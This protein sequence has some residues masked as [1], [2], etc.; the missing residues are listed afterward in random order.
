M[1][2]GGEYDA[3]QQVAGTA[4]EMTI[5]DRGPGIPKEQ[6]DRIFDL[7]YT[8]K[9][10]GSG[11]GLPFAMRAIELNGGKNSD[12][13]RSRPRYR[14]QGNDSDCIQCACQTSGL[15]RCLSESIGNQ[16]GRLSM[17]SRYH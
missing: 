16:S 11:L 3:F 6:L 4:V 7:Y 13:F 2:D 1:P 10:G 5:A 8:T 14:V 12:R 15:Q 9:A 17:S